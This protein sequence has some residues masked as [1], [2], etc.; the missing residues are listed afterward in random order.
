MLNLA[1]GGEDEPPELFTVNM[2]KEE[3]EFLASLITQDMEDY[4]EL[5]DGV[6][7]QPILN[8]LNAIWCGPVFNSS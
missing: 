2:T 6:S 4:P 1:H 3:A 7:I 5:F 8:K